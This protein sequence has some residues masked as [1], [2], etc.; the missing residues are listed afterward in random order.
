MGAQEEVEAFMKGI[1][2]PSSLDAPLSVIDTVL[3]GDCGSELSKLPDGSVNLIVTSP[4]YADRRKSVYGGV[5]PEK[6]VEWFLP[7]AGELHRVLRPDGSF[8][9]IIKEGAAGG[10]R[11]T[12]VIELVLALRQRGWLWV[13]EYHWCKKNTAPGKWPNRFQDRWEHAFHFTKERKFAMYQDAVKEPIGSWAKTRLKRLSAEDHVRHKARTRSGFG[14]K[15]TGWV[16]R[17]T[18]YPSN[19]LHIASGAA[20]TKGHS[21]VFPEL[22]PAWFIRLFTKKGDTVLDPFIGSGTTAVAALGLER[23]YIGIEKLSSYREV[24]LRRIEEARTEFAKRGTP[25][26]Y[27]A[28]VSSTS[29]ESTLASPSNDW[30]D[31]NPSVVIEEIQEL[32]KRMTG[33]LREQS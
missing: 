15:M 8:V 10:E 7:I 6:Y 29:G 13:E 28:P 26:A 31:A 11:L 12:Y 19:V 27:L 9:L 4:P 5:P 16:G 21:A 32:V 2:I 18:I 33:W 30:N 3:L 22:L 24:A 25:S 1:E 23:H 20:T 17:K 14:I